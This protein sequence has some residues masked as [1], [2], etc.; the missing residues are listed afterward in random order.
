MLQRIV[1]LIFLT[2]GTVTDIKYKRIPLRLPAV[3]GVVAVVLRILSPEIVWA[4]LLCGV[5]G[6]LVLIAVSIITGGQIGAGDGILFAVLGI[7]L[8]SSNISVLMIALALCSVIAGVLFVTKHMKRKD[9]LPFIPFVL[10]A[11]VIQQLSLI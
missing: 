6:G 8:G 10:C 1:V 7:L 9:R 3:F 11:Y 5:A 4:E 2:I